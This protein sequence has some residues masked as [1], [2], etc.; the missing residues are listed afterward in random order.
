MEQEKSVLEENWQQVKGMLEEKQKELAAAEESRLEMLARLEEA[1]IKLGAEREENTILRDNKQR[2]EYRL[3][4][5]DKQIL[6][7]MVDKE[8]LEHKLVALQVRFG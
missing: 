5:M 6:E 7:M 4:E 8:D 3:E 2:L 1:E